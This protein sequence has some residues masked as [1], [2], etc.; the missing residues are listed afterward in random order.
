MFEALGH[1]ANRALG[2]ICDENV[3]SPLIA[4][5]AVYLGLFTMLV[6]HLEGGAEKARQLVEE[7][8]HDLLAR[9]S[10]CAFSHLLCFDP[11]FEAVTAPMPEVIQGALRIGWRITWMT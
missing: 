4:N 9:A 10:S 8:S 3:S 11:D 2:S 7:K 6:E 1:R 5:D